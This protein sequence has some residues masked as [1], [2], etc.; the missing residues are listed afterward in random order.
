MTQAQRQV[1]RYMDSQNA[2]ALFVAG[3]WIWRTHIRDF[4]HIADSV[5]ASIASGEARPDRR[6]ENPAYKVEF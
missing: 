6:D 4:P 2:G 1:L 3:A 5:A